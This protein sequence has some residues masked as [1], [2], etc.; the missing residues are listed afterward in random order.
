MQTAGSSS[1]D[2]AGRSAG[3]TV[4]SPDAVAVGP[5]VNQHRLVMVIVAAASLPLIALVIF[6]ILQGKVLAE[7]R[8][9]E[10]RIAL[11]QAGALAASSFVDGNL[12][13]VRSLSRVRTIARPVGSDELETTFKAIQ[14]ENPDWDGWGLASPDGWNVVTTGAPPGTLNIG[15]RPYFQEVLRTGR[16]AISPAVFNRRTG[17][18]TVVLAVPVDLEGLGR[19]AII[20]SLSTARLAA[21]LQA[22]RQDA[23]VRVAL[24]DAEGT[25]IAQPNGEI[26][27]DLPTM[28][29]RPAFDAALRGEVGSL[30]ATDEGTESIVAYAPVVPLGWGIVVSQP[31]ASAFDV[32]RRQTVFGIVILCL[33]VILA[34]TIG[35]Y[36]GGRLADLYRR[37]RAATRRA[38]ASALDLARVSVE[39]DRRR[40]FLE[41]VIESAPVAIAILRGPDYRH[42][43]LNARYEALRPSVEMAGRTIA[44]VFPPA[45]ATAMREIFHRVSLTG[46][47]VVLPDQPL[48]IEDGPGSV[49]PRYFT[50]VVAPLEDESGEPDAILSMVL[51]TTDV[52]LARQRAEREKDEL[53]STASHELKTPLTSLALAAQMIDRMQE[54]DAYDEVRLGRYLGTIRAQVA[55][56]TRL[57]GSLLDV[58]RVETG[59]LVLVWEPVDLG[60]LARMAVA[61]ERD[62]LPEDSRHQLVL[63][64]DSPLVMV[65]GDEAR[66]EQVLAN[67]LSNAVKYSPD[68]GL[69]EVVVWREPSVAI[70]EVVDRGI[71]V[72]LAERPRLFSPFSRTTTAL[73]TGIEGTG[74]GLYISRRIVEA[75]GGSID[76]RDTPGGGATFR[77]TVP[78]RRAA[79]TLEPEALAATDETA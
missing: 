17:Q 6:G 75:H 65:D 63:R 16:P 35:W 36:L 71:G 26:V 49:Q 23:S 46:E 18:P 54:H 14:A 44:E 1:T 68:G 28:R 39:S 12:S 40:R 13:T 25:L 20:V 69:V 74:L 57:I 60:L 66:L 42:E 70:V 21:E 50:Q 8:V 22:L 76:L 53:L 78:V 11:A 56:L 73:G 29:G 4:T 59:R 34:G 77:V 5:V 64:L 7:A 67:L 38:E 10:E 15:D 37:Q 24:V 43:T 9:A 52:V 30:V 72:P 61:R 45:T 79:S 62:S 51:E 58:S 31:T 41:G 48:V 47:Q 2:L 3:A 55:R 33:A 27:A 19:G 32:V